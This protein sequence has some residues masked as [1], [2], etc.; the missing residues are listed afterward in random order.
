MKAS[1]NKKEE[2]IKKHIWLKILIVL[3]IIY[4]AIAIYKYIAI[5]IMN[6]IGNSFSEQSYEIMFRHKTTDNNEESDKII[7][8][9]Y[10]KI[11]NKAIEK[12]YTGDDLDKPNHIVYL[13]MDQKE[14]YEI[15]YDE[16]N[17]KYILL[18]DVKSFGNEEEVE[19]YFKSYSDLNSFKSYAGVNKYKFGYKLNM[20]LN[21]F[22]M[23]NIFSKKVLVYVPFE[24]KVVYEYNNDYLLTKVALN[25]FNLNNSFE[26]TISYDYVPEHFENRE[27][28]NPM[29]SDEYKVVVEK[30]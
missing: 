26:D 15:T 17:E 21:P 22:V 30:Q 3:L 16:E 2:K 18:S 7:N 14:R 13:D 28:S 6:N 27:I 20:A 10:L 11:K 24:Y 4:L 25:N 1:N 29:K 8:S 9:N 5:S 12:T 23:I 19:E